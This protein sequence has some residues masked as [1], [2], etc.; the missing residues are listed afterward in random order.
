M[1]KA[2]SS[3]DAT[4]SRH[5]RFDKTRFCLYIPTCNLKTGAFLEKCYCI[6]NKPCKEA[7][8]TVRLLSITAEFNLA[9]DEQTNESQLTENVQECN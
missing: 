3:A 6:H 9:N 4:A 5:N 1:Y 8:L 7:Q 2:L